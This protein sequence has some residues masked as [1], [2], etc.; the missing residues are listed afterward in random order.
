MS[1]Q[2]NFPPK[3][4]S[5]SSPVAKALEKR[6]YHKFTTNIQ[7]LNGKQIIF[8]NRESE[9]MPFGG[10]PSKDKILVKEFSLKSETTLIAGLDSSCIQV[11]KSEEGSIYAAKIAICFFANRMPCNY[12]RIGPILFYLDESSSNIGVTK[13]VLSEKTLAQRMVRIRMERIAGVELAHHLSK[14]IILFDGS[15]KYSIFDEQKSDL[16]EIIMCAK[17]KSNNIIGFS[18]TS[19][20]RQVN[21]YAGIMRTMT[22][23]PIYSDIHDSISHFMDL[24]GRVLLIKFTKDGLV[25]RADFGTYDINVCEQT[26][27]KIK[28]N[29]RF[30]RGY[31]ESLRIAHHLSIITNSEI[32]S[33]KSYLKKIGAIELPSENVREIILGNL[34]IR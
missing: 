32:F 14:A 33:I 31:P 30:W 20:I 6:L 4:Q 11:A 8:N 7:K 2:L 5:Y 27:S 21:K 18:K 9:L 13:L 17:M 22:K 1:K 19:K 34:K 15:L 16:N 24:K 28:Y 26:L 23:A 12:I 25:F 3:I 10:W 29:D